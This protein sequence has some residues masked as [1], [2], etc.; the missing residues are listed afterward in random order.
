MRI[1][2]E[3]GCWR[4]AYAAGLLMVPP[5]LLKASFPCHVGK[6]L[7]SAWMWKSF[8]WNIRLVKFLKFLYCVLLSHQWNRRLCAEMEICHGHRVHKSVSKIVH[9]NCV[10][11]LVVTYTSTW[12]TGKLTTS[13]Y[14]KYHENCKFS[15]NC[16]K[17]SACFFVT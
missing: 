13:I 17:N 4:L 1:W 16:L 8:W 11:G 5:T 15:F 7:H 10:M 3:K 6:K 12:F 9:H 2:F 14:I